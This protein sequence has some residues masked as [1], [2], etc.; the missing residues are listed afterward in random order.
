MKEYVKL[1]VDVEAY[2][3]GATY[4]EEVF[5]PLETWNEIKDQ[6]EDHLYI[7]ELDGKHSETKCD[8]EVEEDINEK[9]L[10]N[11]IA[12]A[13]DGEDLFY[14]I[15]EF[16]DEDKYDRDYLGIIQEEVENYQ[17]NIEVGYSIHKDDKEKLDEFV[18]NLKN[19][20]KNSH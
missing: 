9:Y 2:Y 7:S 1:S 18:N 8:I 19:E 17:V 16:L 10:E 3:S 13:N 12:S 5:L 15:Y 14:H 11:Y 4:Q 20:R 6:F